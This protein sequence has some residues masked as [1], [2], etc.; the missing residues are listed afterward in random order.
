MMPRVSVVMPV[1]DPHPRYLV[2]AVESIMSQSMSDWELVIVEDPSPRSATEILRHYSDGRIRH[3]VNPART[4]LVAQLNR[5]V[6]LAE[7]E[8]LARLD[9]D[10]VAEP[11]RLEEQCA[12]LDEH[13]D[14]GVLGCQKTVIGPIGEILGVRDY[15]LAH[16]EIVRAIRRYNPLPHP[17]VMM[18]RSLVLATGGYG[19]ERLR[20]AEDYELWWRLL[21]RGVRLANHPKRLLRYRIQRG[22][23]KSRQLREQLRATIAVKRHYFDESFGVV[24]RC[25]LLTEQVLVW[26]PPA[27]VM[28]LFLASQYG[29]AR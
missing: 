19:Y 16:E 26:M 1:L 5:A 11:S 14:T 9:A 25:R 27:L 15:P 20:G 23:V 2:E 10:D 18:R 28:R 7:G 12:Y 4:S 8:Y 13:R 24:D 17:G 6:H 29:P 22:Q 21:T 3:V